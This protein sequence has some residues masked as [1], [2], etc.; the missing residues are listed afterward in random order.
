M[1]QLKGCLDKNDHIIHKYS[2]SNSRQSLTP[3]ERSAAKSQSKTKLKTDKLRSNTLSLA[4][5]IESSLTKLKPKDKDLR[6]GLKRPNSEIK[7]AHPSKSQSHFT[8]VNE[9]TQPS[10][11]AKSF[12]KTEASKPK[13]H[14]EELR[15][16]IE[17]LK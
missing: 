8:S 17:A 9:K 11:Y 12:R 2:T 3:Y 15:R 10:C 5:K 14:R 6:I 1:K 13:S 16:I 4:R 7:S